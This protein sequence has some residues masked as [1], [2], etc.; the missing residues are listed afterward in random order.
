MIFFQALIQ[1]PYDA[2]E[3]LPLMRKYGAIYGRFDS[4]RKNEKPM[5]LHEVWIK[6][7]TTPVCILEQES[8]SALCVLVI[9]G[10]LWVSVKK[11][12]FQCAEILKACLCLPFEMD[13]YL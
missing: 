12:A 1:M 8:C 7:K 5:S 11:T 10:P 13:S 2:P 9:F 6:L 3:R 4:K